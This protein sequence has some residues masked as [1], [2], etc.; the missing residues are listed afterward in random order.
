MTFQD[1]GWGCLVQGKPKSGS[2]GCSPPR[3]YWRGAT[4][5]AALHLIY[6]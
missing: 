4:L 2:T 3:S 5:T 1:L 6:I